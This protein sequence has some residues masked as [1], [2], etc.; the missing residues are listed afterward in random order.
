MHLVN[1]NPEISPETPP[2]QCPSPWAVAAVVVGH[3]VS[4]IG[5]AM[6]QLRTVKNAQI[7]T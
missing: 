4:A 6:K 7:D 2:Q 3:V 1:R 5:S